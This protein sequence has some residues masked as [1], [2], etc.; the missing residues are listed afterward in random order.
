MWIW[1]WLDD[2]A[3]GQIQGWASVGQQ[4]TQ[5]LKQLSNLE[6]RW[7][8]NWAFGTYSA[9]NQQTIQTL[10]EIT[11]SR[12][13]WCSVDPSKKV[14]NVCVYCIL[15]GS[16]VN[17]VKMKG[18][19]Q[20]VS[21]GMAIKLN[22]PEQ[23]Q[24]RGGKCPASWCTSLLCEK[25]RAT[26]PFLPTHIQGQLL[27]SLPPHSTARCHSS[28]DTSDPLPGDKTPLWRAV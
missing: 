25:Q 2:L 5:Q 11:I 8:N 6:E 7:A 3:P 16:H 27:V 9:I 14:V 20:W 12:S 10:K 18:W 19:P 4:N 13:K 17:A 23:L 24:G 15:K 1:G 26:K 21:P 28:K 22:A